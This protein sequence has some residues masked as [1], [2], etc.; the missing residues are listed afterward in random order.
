M[1]KSGAANQAYPAQP[2]S[3]RAVRGGRGVEIQVTG[4]M[5]NIINLAKNS[6]LGIF[7]LGA[8][9]PLPFSHPIDTSFLPHPA[10]RANQRR[11]HGE[12]RIEGG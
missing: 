8:I 12:K 11:K 10:K 4:R 6:G 5:A 2:G 1:P 9:P 3:R 7:P